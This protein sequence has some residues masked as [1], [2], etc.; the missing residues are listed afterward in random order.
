M[1]TCTCSCVV[2]SAEN[3]RAGTL[4]SGLQ[5]STCAESIRAHHRSASDL[6]A[7]E[8]ESWEFHGVFDVAND[9]VQVVMEVHLPWTSAWRKGAGEFPLRHLISTLTYSR[10]EVVCRSLRP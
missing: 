4:E 3:T 8:A 1:L 6:I 7:V 9:S 2:L 10:A 5:C